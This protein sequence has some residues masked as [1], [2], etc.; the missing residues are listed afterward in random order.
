MDI[1]GAVIMEGNTAN[2]TLQ[3]NMGHLPVG[4]Y[5]FYAKGNQAHAALKVVKN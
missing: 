2:A 5:M 3:L 1:T 4:A